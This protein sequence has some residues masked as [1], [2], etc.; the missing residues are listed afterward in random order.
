MSLL[1]FIFFTL[2]GIK[3][4]IKQENVIKNNINLPIIKIISF[5]ESEKSNCNKKILFTHNLNIKFYIKKN[6]KF[7]INPRNLNDIN[8]R[9]TFIIK[10]F[11]ASDNLNEVDLVNRMYDMNLLY[12]TLKE[13]RYDKFASI[14]E[15]LFRNKIKN[16]FEVKILH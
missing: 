16:S 12:L 14:K 13:I 9:C 15:K 10:T 7:I 1:I 8:L 6:N 3:N 2:V 5:L 4:T 11:V